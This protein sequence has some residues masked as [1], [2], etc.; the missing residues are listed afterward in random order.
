MKHITNKSNEVTSVDSAEKITSITEA[1]PPQEE[2]NPS[3][4]WNAVATSPK[5]VFN[6]RMAEVIADRFHIA[7]NANESCVY[8]YE[9]AS[10]CF[11]KTT[12]KTFPV[13]LH[14][15]VRGTDCETILTT[16]NTNEIFSQ[17]LARSSQV[18]LEDFDK[19]EDYIN[20]LNGV[21]NIKSGD[22]MP[23]D[24]KY[25]FLSVINA[26]YVSNDHEKP[27][28]FLKMIE[29]AFDEEED[30]TLF[31]ESLA[32]LISGIYSAKKAIVYVGASNTGKSVILRFLTNIVGKEFVSN[33]PLEKFSD[34]FAIHAIHGK[35]LN[36]CGEQERNQTI[37]RTSI[38][39]GLIGG[40]WIDAEPKGRD[41]YEFLGRAKCLFAC[42]NLPE[43]DPRLM[44]E[45]LTN[46]FIFLGFKNPI[47]EADRIENF[48]EI[49]FKE[50]DAILM[51]LVNTLIK[52]KKNGGKFTQTASSDAM[53][54][55][56]KGQK[57]II[58]EFV[59]DCCEFAS[60]ARTLN[61]DLF[62]QYEEYCST[63]CLEKLSPIMLI[64]ELT[65]KYPNLH[66]HKSHM[67]G[68]NPLWSVQG[69][70]IKKHT[71]K[72]KISGTLE[73]NHHK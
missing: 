68:M 61:S 49:L 67:T 28:N 14:N 42:N 56:F 12:K 2:E 62:R 17:L 25:R 27:A 64:K 37:K 71:T 53:M 7:A 70:R 48:D 69:I 58:E 19:D 44:E 33:V 66:K 22:F 55:R 41:H 51:L 40:D 54:A 47:P 10:G 63:N 1:N 6:P 29:H 4:F 32:Y 35:K 20:V 38:L 21:I 45:A 3:K 60:D 9:P 8:I 16:S 5:K 23:H 24:P 72:C 52:W 50:R 13:W 11:R 73:H 36:V 26:N 34:R 39:K 31:L 30:K 43:I 65:A 18:T 46:R 15:V 57:G 59:E